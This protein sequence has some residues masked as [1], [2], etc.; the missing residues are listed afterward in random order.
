MICQHPHL[1]HIQA[2]YCRWEHGMNK[3]RSTLGEDAGI[4][5]RYILPLLFLRRQ[6]PLWRR[7]SLCECYINMLTFIK[8]TYHYLSHVPLIKGGSKINELEYQHIVPLWFFMKNLH[9]PNGYFEPLPWPRSGPVIPSLDPSTHCSKPKA[10]FKIVKLLFVSVFSRR[11][12]LLHN[13]L[14]FL[15]DK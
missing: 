6:V 9:I 2:H 5:I 14:E 13:C 1:E 7:V 11:T 4:S 8:T 10:V 3:L 12:S 15:T